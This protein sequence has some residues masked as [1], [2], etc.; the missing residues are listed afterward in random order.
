[1]S[2]TNFKPELMAPASSWAMLN[3]AIQN[4]ADAIYFGI[5]KLNMRAAAKNFSINELSEIV[6]ACHSKN[7][8]AYLT[9]NSV[10]QNKELSL[11]DE[12]LL[13]AKKTDVDMIICWDNAVIQGCRELDIPICISTQASISNL[14]SAK[15]YESLGAKRI[16]LAR[17]CS[18]E[19]IVAIKNNVNLEVEVF[20]HGAMCV[21]VSGRCFMSHDVFGKSANKGECLQPCRR[22]YIIKDVENEFEF[23]LGEDYLLSAKDL[24]TIEFIDKLIEA[25]IDSFKIEGRKRSPEYVAKTVSV[26]R[27]AIENYFTD[28]L[29]E[30]KKSSLKIEL[31]K[32]YNKGFSS[33]FYFGVPDGNDFANAEGSLAITT[34]VYAGKVLNYYKNQNVAF[35]LLETGEIKIGDKVLI[36]GSTTGV[37]EFEIEELFIEEEKKNVVNKGDK[38]TIKIP[39]QVRERDKLF[40][41]KQNKKD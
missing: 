21:A 10:I 31:S 40:L 35:I 22:N 24:C 25:K 2:K 4:G 17:E 23:E 32:V 14:K 16:V 34:K 33:G 3:A 36:I 28:S 8:K 1:M 41:I 15:F 26:Y 12:I 27:E 13:E 18:F 9:I 37:V 30:E 6:N 5:E 11:L 20:I 38:F 7:V 19:E 39:T 29:T